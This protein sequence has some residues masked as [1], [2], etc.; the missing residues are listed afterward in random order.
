MT[1][2]N[3]DEYQEYLQRQEDY[4]GFEVLGAICD[5][6]RKPCRTSCVMWRYDHD[7]YGDLALD[8]AG[9]H[10]GYCL[11]ARALGIRLAMLDGKLESTM[12]P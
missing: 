1:A 7:G 4:V 5:R 11:R 8:Y 2:P 10:Q 3:R 9:D 12:Q 6:D